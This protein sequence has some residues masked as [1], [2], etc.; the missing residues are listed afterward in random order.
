MSMKN[1]WKLPLM[2]WI[3]FKSNENCSLNFFLMILAVQNKRNGLQILN[4]LPEDYKSSG[5]GVYQVF[6]KLPRVHITIS[7]A[8]RVFLDICH[9]IKP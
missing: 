9:H 1:L 3:M 4:H 6:E 2:L 7:N 8:K 5:G